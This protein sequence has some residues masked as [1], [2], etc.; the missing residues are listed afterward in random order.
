MED[1]IFW[2][3]Q[4]KDLCD[5]YGKS[6]YSAF[7]KQCD[8]YFYLPHRKESRGVGGIF[9]DDLCI[10]D[11]ET[12]LAF[13]EDVMTTFEDSYFSTFAIIVWGSAT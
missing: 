9:F 2:H 3:Q 5:S 6:L 10:E 1:V 8:Q 4:A 12:S 7:K 13:C 11:F